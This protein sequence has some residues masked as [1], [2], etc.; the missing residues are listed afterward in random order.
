MIS[1]L[2]SKI[3]KEKAAVTYSEAG[4]EAQGNP[5]ISTNYSSQ[6]EGGTPEKDEK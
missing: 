4:T 5:E 6:G 2:L 3:V 1:D